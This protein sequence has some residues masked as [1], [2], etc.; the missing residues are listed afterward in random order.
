[1]ASAFGHAVS[2]LA[3]VSC[4]DIPKQTVLKASILAIGCAIVPDA[5]V[6]AFRFGIPYSHPFGHRGF[7]HSIFFAV[8]FALLIRWSFFYKVRR[9]ST[10]G[11][12][13]FLLFFLSTVSHGILDA[14]TTGGRG[15]AFFGPF[16]NTRHFLPW[17]MIKVSPLSAARFFS[18]W[19]WQV[20]K[21]EFVW[22][23]IPSFL[24]IIFN[25]CRRRLRQ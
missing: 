5:D 23:G 3:I 6:L 17:R 8:L 20:I 2:S 14:M 12:M 21:S 11:W 13:L 15:V 1:M 22:I 19:G 10:K 18:S 16:D 25:W 4:F 9:G 24:I 7:T